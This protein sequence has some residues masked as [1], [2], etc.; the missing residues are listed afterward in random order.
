M[1]IFRPRLKNSLPATVLTS[2]LVLATAGA[3]PAG[4]QAGQAD[5]AST[6]AESPATDPESGFALSSPRLAT[7]HLYKLA[8]TGDAARA[9]EF[10]QTA[11]SRFPDDPPLL[12]A[13]AY[14]RRGSGDY[15]GALQAYQRAAQLD[16]TSANAW[17]GQVLVLRRLGALGPAAELLASHP[18]L[19]AAEEL[20]QIRSEQAAQDLR[21]A[22]GVE[23]RKERASRLAAVLA[24]LDS[25]ITDA[26]GLLPAAHRGDSAVFDRLQALVLMHRESEAAQQFELMKVGGL[27]VPAYAQ[28]QA[29]EA[30]VRLGQLDRAIGML[31]PLAQQH[32]D[33]TDIQFELFYAL[34]DRDRLAQARQLIDRLVARLQTGSDRDAELRGLIAQAMV[35]AYDEQ[36]AKAVARL[37]RI[38][39]SA[40]LSAD[41]RAARA[42]VYQWRGWPRRAD[43]EAAAVLATSPRNRDARALRV[44]AAMDL[45]DWPGARAQFSDAV[46]D[47]ALTERDE[48]LL[49]S[50]LQWQRRPEI[51]L[52]STFG[53]GTQSAVATNREWQIDAQ[54]FSAVWRDRYRFFAHL[55]QSVTDLNPSA[56]VRTWGG[57]GI[58]GTWKEATGS[59]EL[60][61]VSGQ[62]APAAVG[63]AAWL[64]A[65][66][67]RIALTLASSDPDTPARAGA[68]DIRFRSSSLDLDY[69]FTE[70]TAIAAQAQAGRF[71]D[72]N[73]QL[74]SSL[75]LSQRLAAS[76]RSKLVCDASVSVVHDSLPASRAPYFDPAH[77]L[78][79]DTGLRGEWL[80]GRDS[81]RQRSWWHLV[82][83][84]VGT[85]EQQGFGTRPTASASYGQRWTLSNHSE[86]H[87]EAGHGV[88]PY[89]G[90]SES[91]T[92]VSISYEGRL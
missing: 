27:D 11:L 72:G 42:T 79:F 25:L 4:A 92:F 50:R 81:P 15:S 22:D 70:S 69:D 21:Y 73:T 71:S 64:P 88:H 41:A 36:P 16:P 6:A 1:V 32:P 26:G 91:R 5:A 33:D 47:G 24:T 46:A 76:V 20:R 52:S 78:A 84:S 44:Q 18:E 23:D 59:L 37:D 83:L 9:T 34:V 3:A 66:G 45:G 12:E 65:D 7:D 77:A 54:A 40:P 61:G 56:Y 8:E 82:T 90:R 19:N 57:A 29:A 49:G 51:R 60:A 35:D 63:R 68:A 13:A 28:L 31:E 30:Y 74:G 87:F 80:G 85:Y 89:D 2:W 75:R 48:Q 14:V 58:E 17:K 55:K 43:S 53:T 62:A 10:A 86:L 39:A 67:A 38:L